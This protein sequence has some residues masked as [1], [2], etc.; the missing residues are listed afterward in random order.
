MKTLPTRLLPA[1]LLLPLLVFV[2]PLA[3]QDNSAPAWTAT[4][5]NG[6]EVAFPP[7]S[8]PP[9]VLL[10]WATWCPYCKGL[11]PHLQSLVDEYGDEKIR[12]LAVSIFEEDDANPAAYLAKQGFQFQ[13]V[14]KGETIAKQY[15]VKG[16]PGLFLVEQG[17]VVWHLGLARQAESR[18]EGVKG[19]GLRAARRA[20]FWAAELRKAV[21]MF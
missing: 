16:T 10:F 8:G 5:V 15:G 4:D 17:E 9:T 3:A 2:S 14:E 6:H 20:P 12:V 21:D 13:L 19:H 18:T 1:L 7:A 11:M